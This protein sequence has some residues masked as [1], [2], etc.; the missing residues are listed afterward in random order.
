MN[1]THTPETLWTDITAIIAELLQD[2]GE[3]AGDISPTTMLNADLGISSVEAIHL[4]IMLEDRLE[5]P[6]NFQ[7]LAVRDGEYVADL[8]V[9]DVHRFVAA[10]V[11]A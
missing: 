7:E 2:R 9:G 11:G 10:S 8:S 4:M 3:I 5:A 1:K 6:L